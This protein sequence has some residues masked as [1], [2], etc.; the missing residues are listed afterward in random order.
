ML[1]NKLLYLH[2]IRDQILKQL[3]F[4]SFNDIQQKF[5]DL[6]DANS[7]IQFLAPTGSGKT[8]AFIT[9]ILERLNNQH[10]GMQALIMV[11]GRELALQIESVFKQLKTGYKVVCC[12]GGHD[13][14]KESNQLIETPAIV[15]GTPGRLAQHIE[16]GKIKPEQV[17]ILVI[18]EFDKCLEQ[19]F[20]EDM[21]YIIRRMSHY[22][23]AV[24]C[25]ATPVLEQAPYLELSKFKALDLRQM[26]I[27]Q[28]GRQIFKIM[29]SNKEKLNTLIDLVT[30]IP[31]ASTLI[32]CN[33]RNEVDELS[34]E[35]KALGF[36]VAPYHG[37]L[38]QKERELNLFKFDNGSVALFVC[39]DLAA[40]GLDLSQ[41]KH[42]I[43][44]TEPLDEASFIHRN[45][46]SGRLQQEAG[47]VYLFMTEDS[48]HQ[49][50]QDAFDTL[51]ISRDTKKNR[52]MAELPPYQTYFI[53]LG[54][55]QNLQKGDILGFF[56]KDIGLDGKSIGKIKIYETYSYVAISQ[57]LFA[58]IL[59]LVEGK[60][61]KNKKFKMELAN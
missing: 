44:F 37:A 59:N 57:S 48:R 42:V 56:T 54:K 53:S 58:Q 39:T 30:Q 12:Y 49:P 51:T 31:P 47:Q 28:S 50:Y 34:D 29:T 5:L 32:F 6:S 20:D 35:L 26:A 22:K 52:P 41:V 55:K 10:S 3:S 27:Q 25:S 21:A 8:L 7:H 61:M 1:I 17:N 11:P 24:L 2:V 23:F 43:H 33:T 18:D 60:K 14:K 38:E 45:G 46:R 15:I 36:V 4:S 9:F 19:G 13:F 16:L 40:R